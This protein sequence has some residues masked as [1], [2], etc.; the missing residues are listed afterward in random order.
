VPLASGVR[1]MLII[2]LEVEQFGLQ[3]GGGPE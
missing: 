1:A 2:M 3:V